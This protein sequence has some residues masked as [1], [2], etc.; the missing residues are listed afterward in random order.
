MRL[1]NIL[2][3]IFGKRVLVQIKIGGS[4]GN[5]IRKH[6]E[7][8]YPN[9]CCGFLLGKIENN[10]RIVN[11]TKPAVNSREKENRYNRY[12]ISPEEYRRIERQAR[13]ENLEVIGIYHS[14]PDAEAQPSKFDLDNSWP[15]YSYVILSVKKGKPGVMTSWRLKDDRSAFNEEE[16]I[17]E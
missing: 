10:T 7:A 5:K 9:E 6:G 1:L 2:D 8:D 16:L 15:F 17:E 3:N 14:H 11:H 4:V 12:Y 13:D